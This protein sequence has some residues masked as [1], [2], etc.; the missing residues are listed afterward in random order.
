MEN[1]IQFHYNIEC[2]NLIEKQEIY[3]FSVEKQNFMLSPFQ[4]S[5]EELE[6]IYQIC[7]ELK[8]MNYPVHTFILNREG[9]LVSNMNDHSYILLKLEENNQKEFNIL[10]I[11]PFSNGLHL[12]QTKSKLYRNLWGELWSKKI[13]YFEY[14]VHE[15]GKEKKIILNSFTYYVGLAENAISYVNSTLKKNPSNVA[16]ITLC[17]KRIHF[18]NPAEEYLNPLT[19]V[20]DLNIRDIAEYIKS[21]F[22][23]NEEDAWIE[24]KA[25]L[26]MKNYTLFDYEMFYARLLYPSYYF[27]IY[28]QVMNKEIEEEKLIPFIKKASKYEEF[29]NKVYYEIVKIAPIEK[30]EWIIE[31]NRS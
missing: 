12:S 27:D 3:Y 24:L 5:S 28:E 17:H 25:F 15:L 23:V 22:F 4:R 31:K 29:L 6:D 19:F 13:D 7:E 16:N 18:P 30:I 10:D 26:S 1:M 14:Q 8:R 21:A 11:I 9:K 20:F 2:Q